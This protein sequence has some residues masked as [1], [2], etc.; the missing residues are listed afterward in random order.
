MKH[1]PILQQW[2][3]E[4]PPADVKAA[5]ARLCRSHDVARVAVMPDVHLAEEVCVGTVVATRTALLPAAVLA[6]LARAIPTL[7]HP[8]GEHPLPADLAERPLSTPALESH[9]RRTAGLQLGTLGRGNHFVEL[10]ADDDD[11]LWLM[12]HSGSRSL[13]QAIRDHH[14]TQATPIGGGLRGIQ[15]ESP[16]GAAYLADMA[17]ALDY[18]ARSRERL[19]QRAAEVVATCLK[20]QAVP[21]SGFACHH[22]FVRRET[23]AGEAMWVHRKGAISAALDEPG[24]IPGSMG[25]PSYHVRGRGCTAALC[26]SSHGAG[27]QLARSDARRR[28]SREALVEQ[29]RGVWFDHRSAEAL[30]DEAP[31]AYKNIGAVMRA[32]RELTRVVRTLRPLLCFKGA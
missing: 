31:A 26:S 9:K 3:A 17:W 25:A 22:N 10:Q 7:R 20:V 14:D 30:R 21:D 11:R 15:G 24:V 28:I 29:M 6:G 19:C 4:P 27:R 8:H 13:G 2:T 32:Q 16:E 23:H 12:V 18:A 5:L 1:A